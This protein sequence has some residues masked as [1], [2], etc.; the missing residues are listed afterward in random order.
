MT[1]SFGMEPGAARSVY[2]TSRYCSRSAWNSA[3]V[4]D[5]NGAGGVAAEFAAALAFAA[6]IATLFPF[7]AFTSNLA[8]FAARDADA[9]SRSAFHRSFSFAGSATGAEGAPRTD[10][11]S[12]RAIRSN[13]HHP[14]GETDPEAS[15]VAVFFD[16][17]FDFD[18]DVAS[19]PP[20]PPPSSSA[21]L[22]LGGA[23]ERRAATSASTT[24]RRCVARP[25]RRRGVRRRGG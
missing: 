16:L 18:L 15:A 7:A 22:Y 23:A 24:R 5:A 20:S 9:G 1:G 17:D 12:S 21:R 4:F 25:F 8:R 3:C 10:A 13:S 11:P 19:P 6:S 2:T 14:P